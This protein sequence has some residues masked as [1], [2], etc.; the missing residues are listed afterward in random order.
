MAAEIRADHV[1]SLLR[2]PE[3]LEA[4]HKAAA[5]E[6]GA[7]ALEAAE[8][9]AIDWVLERQTLTGIGVVSDGEFRRAGWYDS[10]RAAAEGF[11]P[12]KRTMAA[13][14]KG[15]HAHEAAEV[16][17]AAGSF[18][19]GGKLKLHGRFT[20]VE[21]KYLVAHAPKP[22][23]ITVPSPASF[24][25]FFEPGFSESA[26]A[27]PDAMLSDIVELY[28]G[29]MSA[30][31]NDGVP[32]I[33]LDSLRYGD[34]IDPGR[35][36]RWKARGVDP[37][38]I[39]D[40]TLAADNTILDLLGR[41]GVTRA[42]HICRGNN[43]SAWAGE[44]GYEPVAE[45]MLGE[46]RVDRFLLEYDD[47]RSGGFEPLRFVPKGKIAALGLVTTKTGALEDQDQLRRRIDEA[48]KFLPLE[49]LA[50][51]TQCGFA[52]M[53]SGNVITMDDQWRKLELI[54]DTARKVWG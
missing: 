13:I 15:E 4:R 37:M 7:E 18:V 23:K 34:A 28:K 8:D 52:S 5:G 48:A 9:R 1:G 46:L 47:A 42:M 51:T 10:F 3:L 53:E 22:F 6:L 12:H 54:A 30:L 20:D 27:D 49:Q 19:V 40:Q 35:R 24:Q 39:V 36:E 11:V 45:R 25:Q 29:E 38:K 33:Q 17:E 41:P 21:A 44:G 43:R 16:T 14:W 2:P 32:Y 31:A 50:L 26:Y